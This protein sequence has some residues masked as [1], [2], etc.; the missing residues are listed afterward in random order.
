MAL[1]LDDTQSAVLL[2][3]LGLPEDTDD[4]SLV[5]DTVRDAVAVEPEAP[6]AIA[7][8]AKKHGLELLDADSHE[9]LKR[10]AAEGRRLRAAADQAKVEAQVDAAIDKGKIAASRRKHWVSLIAADAGMGEVLASIPDETAVPLSEIGHASA[11]SE[12]QG[13]GSDTG[14]GKWFW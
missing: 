4:V 12:T 11:E 1:T 13:A 8:A 6:S 3:L 10:D 7:A 2:A 5:L 14:V 9:A